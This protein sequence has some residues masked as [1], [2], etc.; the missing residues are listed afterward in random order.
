MTGSLRCAD[1]GDRTSGERAR[2]CQ[3]QPAV[4]SHVWERDARQAE[5]SQRQTLHQ[6]LHATLAPPRSQRRS[7]RAGSLDTQH[8][9]PDAA[10]E[11]PCD[12]RLRAPGSPQGG[13]RGGRSLYDDSAG[14]CC[15]AVGE[16]DV[17]DALDGS[18]SARRLAQRV[19]AR[20]AATLRSS[21]HSAA[22]SV[23]V[24]VSRVIVLEGLVWH[25][26]D[27]LLN[28]QS[29]RPDGWRWAMSRANLLPQPRSL[30]ALSTLERIAPHRVVALCAVDDLDSCVC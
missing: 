18:E 13:G 10:L 14:R 1:L 22:A 7:R 8:P 30:A 5:R 19:S 24:R 6:S 23:Q 9:T 26:A 12:R 15:S 4:S 29:G 20:P 28:T 16:G 3:I 21:R 11:D 2:R 17:E 25:L 27:L